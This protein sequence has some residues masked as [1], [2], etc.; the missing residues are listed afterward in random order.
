MY[1]CS[2]L[3]TALHGFREAFRVKSIP[4]LD[5]RA[6]GLGPHEGVLFSS[7]KE[8]FRELKSTEPTPIE[9]K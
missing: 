7:P 8:P 9:C 5:R 3:T 6:A 2:P 4:Y 1:V